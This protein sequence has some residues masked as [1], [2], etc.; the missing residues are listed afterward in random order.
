MSW[1]TCFGI[2]LGTLVL[3]FMMSIIKYDLKNKHIVYTGPAKFL[4]L[5]T[6][7]KKLEV[8]FDND[9]KGYLFIDY[10]SVQFIENKESSFQCKLT[11]NG[12]AML[13]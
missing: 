10:N 11:E 9:M 13:E 4:K 8:V 1:K 12:Q 2:F 3:H 6:N 7:T 5:D